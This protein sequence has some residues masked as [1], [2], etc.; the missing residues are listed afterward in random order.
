MANIPERQAFSRNIR[1]SW[2]VQLF[3][4]IVAR[5][6]RRGA[7][8]L[9]TQSILDQLSIA[10]GRRILSAIPPAPSRDAG[11]VASLDALWRRASAL[12][13]FIWNGLGVARC[14]ARGP[15]GVNDVI[16]A[17]LAAGFESRGALDF[18]LDGLGLVISRLSKDAL[19]LA[20]QAFRRYRAAGGTR[21]NVR[22][23]FF[24]GAQAS[25][26][27]RRLLTPDA[28]MYHTYFPG[29]E[30]LGVVE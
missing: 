9:L 11:V 26:E 5:L 20:G 13:R 2:R 29:I 6:A 18:E 16:Y 19:F 23:D 7:F 17:E 12:F 22:A 1:A 4:F 15:I 25:A 14:A 28:P 10:T 27:G 8:T 21:P 24:I 30:V 3:G